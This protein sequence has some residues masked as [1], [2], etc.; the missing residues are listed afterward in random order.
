[1]REVQYTLPQ[2]GGKDLGPGE[3]VMSLVPDEGS[4]AEREL[5]AQ[6]AKERGDNQYGNRLVLH[7]GETMEQL[8]QLVA[9]RM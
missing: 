8:K 5:F 4:G 3:T 9:E 1:M 2:M 6:L 7:D